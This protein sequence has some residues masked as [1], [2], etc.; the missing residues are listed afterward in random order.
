MSYERMPL[1]VRGLQLIS[2][3]VGAEAFNSKGNFFIIDW[4][5]HASY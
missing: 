4:L 5:N 2:E 3:L 1:L